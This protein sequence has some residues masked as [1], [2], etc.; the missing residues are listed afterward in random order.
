MA[1]GS[2]GTTRDLPFDLAFYGT[3]STDGW[4]RAVGPAVPESTTDPRKIVTLISFEIHALTPGADLNA[5][6]QVQLGLAGND[7]APDALCSV[8]LTDTAPST[9]QLIIRTISTQAPG[10][11]VRVKGTSGS[12]RLRQVEMVQLDLTKLTEGQHYHWIENSTPLNG[13][14]LADSPPSQTD[15]VT[16]QVAPSVTF[17]NPITP[18]DNWMVF[19]GAE[20]VVNDA[21]SEFGAYW[22]TDVA[23]QWGQTTPRYYRWPAPYTGTGEREWVCSQRT[24]GRIGS[25]AVFYPSLGARH[26]STSL[27][28]RCEF[29]FAGDPAK[30]S[31]LVRQKWLVIEGNL[32]ASPEIDIIYGHV[33]QTSAGGD[34][35]DAPASSGAPTL[36]GVLIYSS[37]YYRVALG[38]TAHFSRIEHQ[39]ATDGTVSKADTNTRAAGSGYGFTVVVNQGASVL[40]TM[41]R[42]VTNDVAGAGTTALTRD[43]MVFGFAFVATTGLGW[44]GVTEPPQVGLTTGAAVGIETVGGRFEISPSGDA[45]Q[46]VVELVDPTRDFDST[47]MLAAWAT[48][49]IQNVRSDSELLTSARLE[50]CISRGS[51]QPVAPSAWASYPL[52]NMG[53]PGYALLT[54][55]SRWLG[56]S[57]AAAGGISVTLLDV[58]VQLPALNRIGAPGLWARIV[59]NGD[60]VVGNSVKFDVS[61][62]AL[63][64][65][66]R[67]NIGGGFGYSED[68]FVSDYI[69]ADDGTNAMVAV[70][71]L[72][73]QGP[74]PVVAGDGNPYES[75]YFAAF[76]GAN[77]PVPEDWRT[78]RFACFTVVDVDL[79][80]A[81]PDLQIECIRNV[82]LGGF[83]NWLTSW[84][85]GGSLASRATALR[86]GRSQVV[87]V[88][89]LEPRDFPPNP[90]S[91]FVDLGGQTVYVGFR[92][93]E[94][95]TAPSGK[96]VR[97]RSIAV[98]VDRLTENGG[99]FLAERQRGLH[100]F[101]QPRSYSFAGVP[102]T[103]DQARFVQVLLSHYTGSSPYPAGVRPQ[104][105]PH[106]A[107]TSGLLGAGWH[108]VISTLQ[109]KNLV[110][111]PLAN[112][113]V[114]DLAAG[115]SGVIEAINTD[116]ECDPDRNNL[117][118]TV[119]LWIRG[120]DWTITALAAPL[121]P[122]DP[123]TSAPNPGAPGLEY[124]PP[125]R[126]PSLA[127]PSVIGAEREG[128]SSQGQPDLPI[129]PDEVYSV[130]FEVQAR[131]MTS[132][133]G[134]P[135]RWPLWRSPRRTYRMVW[136][137]VTTG[138]RDQLFEALIATFR[139]TPRNDLGNVRVESIALVPIETPTST[140]LGAGLHSVTCTS[141]ELIFVWPPGF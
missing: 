139:W 101:N 29:R 120:A 77:E 138:Q 111:I 95:A 61:T 123:G 43:T 42:G 131:R 96:V 25:A 10:L 66:Y 137:G 71:G 52:V 7:S 56:G 65:F 32:F 6:A 40:P 115:Q 121:P 45:W 8:K 82:V 2:A 9:V 70:P 64:A 75:S 57:P 117:E 20:F 104:N 141:A 78:K 84:Q 16:S 14:T 81:S 132:D 106:A 36:P 103:A 109:T 49:F 30:T 93:A 88:A 23:P 85:A 18:Q 12:F 50:V 5:L 79:V 116:P 113:P 21:S 69:V 3:G 11:W 22:V 28:M 122:L 124:R 27:T 54:R 97:I 130:G 44:V 105:G 136:N 35:Y 134:Q 72:G 102:P 135:L 13:V 108:P 37:T 15:S 91:G 100:K 127:P 87:A 76:Q 33:G 26:G 92:P 140:G 51:A 63:V 62:P 126:R 89:E 58:D 114:F 118:G 107:K 4:L 128:G 73:D 98:S 119:L 55:D 133:D 90:I 41:V 53:S 39:N 110:A 67:D 125:R 24:T 48:C 19:G 59:S 46:Q 74:L 38:P 99:E 80:E 129:E 17:A 60:D 47:L 34:S 68:F 112:V 94:P 31:T 83:G 86:V 1:V